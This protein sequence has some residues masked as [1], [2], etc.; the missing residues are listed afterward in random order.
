MASSPGRWTSASVIFL[1][2][3]TSIYA[4]TQ[5][6]C[7]V[8]GGLRYL[9]TQVCVCGRAPSTAPQSRPSLRTKHQ[10]MHTQ[11]SAE[12]TSLYNMHW[13]FKYQVISY[14]LLYC[15]SIE[16]WRLPHIIFAIGLVVVRTSSWFGRRS[17][18][19][20]RWRHYKY[21]IVLI[22]LLPRSRVASANNIAVEG[23]QQRESPR[24]LHIPL[25]YG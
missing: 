4:S 20:V 25:L 15:C 16:C 19:K 13:Y 11:Y 23:D 24:A 14:S 17:I 2:L 12:S 22:S 9:T 6:S 18:D 7:L 21:H 8:A 1:N 3:L 10:S 5:P